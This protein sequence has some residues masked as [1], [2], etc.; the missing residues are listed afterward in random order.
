MNLKYKLIATDFDG[1]LLNDKGEV[2]EK[3]KNELL[4]Y[5]RNGYI[6]VAVTG[7]TLDAIIDLIDINIFD[8]LLLNNGA[9]IYNVSNKMGEYQ[10]II[11]KDIMLMIT[12]LVDNLSSRI[13]YCSATKYYNYKEKTNNLVYEVI[14]IDSPRN[15]G[16][17]IAKIN[18]N[19]IDNGKIYDIVRR[20]NDV[21][22]VDSFVMQD[23]NSSDR[24]I[25]VMPKGVNKKSGLQKLCNRLNIFINIS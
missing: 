20:I 14:D 4:N 6:I 13:I 5:K 11:E 2:S 15:I 19:L 21:Y 8:Y 16:D 12:N 3:N 24:H 22:D 17:K 7:R 23:S 25:C 18:I 1:T 10:S 9:Y